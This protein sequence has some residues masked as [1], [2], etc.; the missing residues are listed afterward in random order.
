[1]AITGSSISLSVTPCRVV[2]PVNFNSGFERAITSIFTVSEYPPAD[3]VIVDVPTATE[4]NFIPSTEITV[5]SLDITLISVLSAVNASGLKATSIVLSPSPCTHKAE[6]SALLVIVTSLSVGFTVIRTL[7]LLSSA[8]TVIVAEPALNA[9]RVLPSVSTDII[10]GLFDT[11][12]TSALSADTPFGIKVNSTVLSAPP[13][14]QSD[15]KAV[16][17]LILTDSIAGISFTALLQ[18]TKQ[19]VR[20]KITV[21]TIIQSFLRF[22]VLPPNHILRIRKD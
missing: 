19:A 15:C 1:M 7:S 5:G 14:Y 10:C 6:S 16:L 18:P 17:L 2:S 8:V 9:F 13:S 20:H 4:V 21:N 22:I 3:T 11:T 12:L